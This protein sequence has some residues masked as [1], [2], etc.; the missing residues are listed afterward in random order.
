MKKIFPLIAGLGGFLLL[1]LLFGTF[2]GCTKKETTIVYRDTTIYAGDTATNQQTYIAL[3]ETYGSDSTTPYA[4]AYYRV[5]AF[6][7]REYLGV[8]SVVLI[9]EP[10]ILS[11]TG[12]IEARLYDFTDN[13][14]IGGSL[15]SG[16]TPANLSQNYPFVRSANFIDSIPRKPIDLGIEVNVTSLPTTGVIAESYL[17]LYR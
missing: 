17:I 14:A 5:P 11:G 1:F 8:D 15:V 2:T 16:A 13:K 3:A 12:S 6:D 4:Y 9:C 10:Y 7:I